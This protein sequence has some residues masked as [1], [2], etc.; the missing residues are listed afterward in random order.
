ML[1][2][3]FIM[4]RMASSDDNNVIGIFAKYYNDPMVNITVSGSSKQY[5]NGSRQMTKPEYAIYPFA[6]AY[7]WCSNCPRSYDEH[8]WIV[9]TLKNHRMQFSS[10][11]LRAGCCYYE[12]CCCD[13]DYY[14]CVDCCLYS[15]SLQVSDDNKTWTEAHRV[16][17]D[18]EMRRCKEK[19]YQLDK[20]Y[21]ARYVRLIQNENCP[22]WPPCIAINKLDLFG[23]VLNDD[24]SPN[25]DF[26]S[27]HDDDND[28]SIIGHISR[29]GKL[30]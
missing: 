28:V 6:K 13:D 23:N 11:L 27:Y 19:T 22:G 5:I 4:P 20:T 10:Y 30:N 21:T 2:F 3:L 17:K 9:F 1:S 16:D 29:N 12:E 15:W 8:P 26:V 25:D 14:G 7:D 24:Y 18:R